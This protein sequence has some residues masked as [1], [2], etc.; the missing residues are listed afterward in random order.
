MTYQAVSLKF[1]T[2]TVSRMQSIMQSLKNKEPEKGKRIK[3]QSL[4]SSKRK[5]KRTPLPNYKRKLKKKR[6][7]NQNN[8]QRKKKGLQKRKNSRESKEIKFLKRTQR[9]GSLFLIKKV[10]TQLVL[11]LTFMFRSK[12]NSSSY[13]R[14][15]TLRR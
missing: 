9:R 7:L 8:R 2:K 1:L 3:R 13:L 4:E 10:R 5:L 14:N 15:I 6:E 12:K 11:T